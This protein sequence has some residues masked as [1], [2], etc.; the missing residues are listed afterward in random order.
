M[1]EQSRRDEGRDPR[2]PLP[3]RDAITPLL[4]Y[5]RTLGAA[6]TTTGARQMSEPAARP[7]ARAAR[8][9]TAAAWLAAAALIGFV[10]AHGV[11][12]AMVDL[13]VY[14]SGALTVLHGRDLYDMRTAIG[15][16]FTYPP[17]SAILAMPLL[18]VPWSVARAAWTAMVY[19]PLGVAV[20]FGFRPLLARAGAYAPA[21]FA[22]ALGCC[23]LLLPLRQEMYLGQVDIFLVALCLLDC[24]TRQPR[25]P[26]GLLVGLAT[27]IKLVPGV[28]I[29]YLLITGRRRAAGVAA[30]SFA[31]WT[32]LTFLI[33]PHDSSVY[34]T[35]AV[36]D[37]NRLGGNASAG[38]QSLRGMVLRAFEP[39]HAPALA[40]LVLAAV[41]AVAGFAAARA[42]WR[43][44]DDLAGIVIT[45]FLAAALSPVAWIHHI[46]WIVVA[47]GV[48]LGAARSWRRVAV[49]LA[50]F[51]LFATMLPVWAQSGLNAGHLPVMPARLLEDSFGLAALALI[52]VLYWL[53]R[54]RPPLAVDA[55]ASG[56]PAP[57]GS[58][59]ALAAT[60]AAVA[61]R[62]PDAPVLTGEPGQPQAGRPPGSGVLAAE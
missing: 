57:A 49:A 55:G 37:S 24:G 53:A 6:L 41:V 28:F 47:I 13:N 8:L 35:S 21:A 1:K 56:R 5:P 16:Q 48:I 38:N 58:A 15:L 3:A 17:L 7:P 62:K 30:L 46:C 14:R 9:A 19:V 11:P 31:G 27:A 32:G 45:G 39:A 34:W 42:C 50:T 51:G 18:L 52:G 23:A 20:W 2:C 60:D 29:V 43:H 40:W 10:I 33:A 25:W 26:R 36:F 54:T 61:G 44:G 22:L 12:G 4:A 59:E